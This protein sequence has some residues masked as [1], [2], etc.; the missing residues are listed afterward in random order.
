[1]TGY[2]ASALQFL[3][4]FRMYVIMNESF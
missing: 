3:G 4:Y 2:S 1:M